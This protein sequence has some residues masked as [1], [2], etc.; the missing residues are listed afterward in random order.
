MSE[1]NDH[2]PGLGTL[3]GRLTRTGVGAFQNRIEL[4]ALE[5]R[6]ERLRMTSMMAWLVAMLFLAMMGL[7]LLT[8]TIIFLFPQEW[9]LY[10]TA[11]FTLLYLGGAVGAWVGLRQTL[12]HEPFDAS[13]EELKKDRAWL[14]SLK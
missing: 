1:T 11:A 9:R 7:M 5:W 10:V 2:P 8:A 14:D 6:E 4:F 13:I 3:L 12:K